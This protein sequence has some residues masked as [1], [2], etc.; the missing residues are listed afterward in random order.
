LSF[1]F[2]LIP[3]GFWVRDTPLQGRLA[4]E[5]VMTIATGVTCEPLPDGHILVEFQ[6]DDGTTLCSQVVT[7][8]VL[9]AIPTVASW[10]EL[11]LQK[12]AEAVEKITKQ[13]RA[14]EAS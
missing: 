10:A 13:L 12:G 6:T 7:A 1:L 9:R 5:T 14:V 3:I 8:E 2:P 11:V 4:E